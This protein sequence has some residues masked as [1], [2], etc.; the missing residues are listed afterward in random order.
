MRARLKVNTHMIK[1]RQVLYKKYVEK[2]STSDL[3]RLPNREL[4]KDE[5]NLDSN[6]E[7]LFSQTVST[8]KR[9][10][11]SPNHDVVGISNESTTRSLASRD[12]I[13]NIYTDDPYFHAFA[14][15]TSSMFTT[16]P[17][18][19]SIGLSLARV[20]GCIRP[21]CHLTLTPSNAH[22]AE[23]EEEHL[24]SQANA[25]K[26]NSQLMAMQASLLEHQAMSLKHTD[27]HAHLEHDVNLGNAVHVTANHE[28]TKDKDSHKETSKH[29][30]E[31][32]VSLQPLGL[33]EVTIQKVSTGYPVYN[34]PTI[35]VTGSPLTDFVRPLPPASGP[36]PYEVLTSASLGRDYPGVSQDNGGGV[37]TGAAAMGVATI[38]PIK[39]V[40]SLK[41]G[42]VK[43]KYNNI[44]KR[45]KEKD[46]DHKFIKRIGIKKGKRDK[47][48]QDK[49]KRTTKE[50]NEDSEFIKRMDIKK[51]KR[52]KRKQD[53][54]KTRKNKNAKHYHRKRRKSARK[55]M[56]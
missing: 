8:S 6:R 25:L 37:N 54:R 52:D 29:N 30:P 1:R 55:I 5:R 24:I 51:G 21:P 50:K 27:H 18:H 39:V 17:L 36:N 46:E 14:R 19:D 31:S 4:H 23:K 47:R 26:Q 10:T 42:Y 3:K 9:K 48:K 11:L 2:N 49:R 35:Q 7:K 56:S 13:Q 45:T 12:Y 53:K 43:K 32:L 28:E 15:A 33:G 41:D 40:V 20:D 22:S 16:D 44:I 34:L 38:K